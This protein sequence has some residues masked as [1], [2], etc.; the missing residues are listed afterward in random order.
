MLFLGSADM[1]QSVYTIPK[2]TLETF[3]AVIQSKK[4]LSLKTTTIILKVITQPTVT[5]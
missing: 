1:H 5:V 4:I 2:N 3:F